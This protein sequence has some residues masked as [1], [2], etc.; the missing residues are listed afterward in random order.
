MAEYAVLT[1]NGRTYFSKTSEGWAVYVYR[2][3]IGTGGHNPTTYEPLEITDIDIDDLTTP[4]EIS[5]SITKKLITAVTR[6]NDN[7]IAAL[8]KI[9]EDEALENKLSEIGIW[10]NIYDDSQILQDE[11]LI[12]VVHFPPIYRKGAPHTQVTCSWNV[13]ISF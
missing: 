9:E 4:I 10:A 5:P 6:P 8:C 3:S 2:F 7:S 11:Y 12:A 13:I 1:T